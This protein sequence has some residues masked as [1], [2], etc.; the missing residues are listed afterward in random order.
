MKYE[1]YIGIAVP[2]EH[3]FMGVGWIIL[4]ADGQ[5]RQGSVAIK[6]GIQD[7]K[8]AH[9][10]AMTHALKEIEPQSHVD[11][12]TESRHLCMSVDNTRV[13]NTFHSDWYLQAFM[14]ARHSLTS[15]AC[16][17]VQLT[18]SARAKAL[19][20]EANDL[21]KDAL[22]ALSRRVARRM[23]TAHRDTRL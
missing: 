8:L 23:K 11:V 13:M 17:S 5:Y 18:D 16:V 4:G 2:Q 1:A 14:E 6:G 20:R 19:T 9:I 3:T 22:P 15:H 7:P 12:F 10:W 21:A